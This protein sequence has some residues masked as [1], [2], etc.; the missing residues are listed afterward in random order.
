MKLAAT[1]IALAAWVSIAHAAGVR[2]VDSVVNAASTNAAV[3]GATLTDS[4]YL[5]RLKVSVSANGTTDVSVVDSDGTAIATTNGLAGSA[6]FTPNFATT[7][8]S[9]RT[10]NANN[11][12]NVTRKVTATFTFGD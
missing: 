6:T 10:A 3:T 11:T 12:T 9:I 5:Y 1:V 4:G 7:R 2:R 8:P